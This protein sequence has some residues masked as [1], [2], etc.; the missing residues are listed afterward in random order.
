M[1]QRNN[2][3]HT[4]KLNKETQRLLERYCAINN[5]GQ[6]VAIKHIINL[7]LTDLLPPIEEAAENQLGL[8]DPIQTQ[9]F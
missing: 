4:I 3:T 7:Y 1:K 2:T 5:V 9:L 6:K 8:F